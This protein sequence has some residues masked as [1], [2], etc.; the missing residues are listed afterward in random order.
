[1]KSFHDKVAA[2]TG[3][4]SGMG[5]ELAIELAK[6]GCHVA[7]SDVNENGL[8][9]TVE[10]LKAYSVRVT[11][12][13]LDVANR[14]AVYAWADQVVADHGKVNLVFNNAGVA[15]GA[16]LEGVSY[17]DFEWIMNINFWGVVY[18]SKAFLPHLRAS[19]DGHVINT[20]SVFGLFAV[21]GNGCY[22]ASKFAVRGFNECLRQELE[23]TRAPVSLTSVHPGGI[24]TG[25]AQSARMTKSLEGVLAKDEKSAKDN[26]D[27]LFITTANRAALIILKAV[28]GNKR[29]VLVGPDAK[30]FDVMVRM[31][32]AAHQRLVTSAARKQAARSGV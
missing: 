21:P 8:A 9:E 4:G 2:I 25:I 17:E 19:G 28:Q 16:T 27:K 6:Q 24:K 10:Q 14:E 20:S 18:G 12:Q 3:A 31:L 13:S 1:M 23:L 30:L 29:R 15:L 7:I 11:A 32:P 5:R 22:N 26:F